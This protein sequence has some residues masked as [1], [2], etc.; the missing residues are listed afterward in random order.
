MFAAK[1]GAARV[2]G[3][4]CSNIAQHAETIVKANNLDHIVTIV[5]GKT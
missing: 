5:K 1:A 3:I 4:E 2:I